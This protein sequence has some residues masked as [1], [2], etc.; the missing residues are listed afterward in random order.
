MKDLNEQGANITWE[1]DDAIKVY[2][3]IEEYNF[4]WVKTCDDVAKYFKTKYP[5]CLGFLR[6]DEVPD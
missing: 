4:K 3:D 1:K 2:A 5:E 6:H